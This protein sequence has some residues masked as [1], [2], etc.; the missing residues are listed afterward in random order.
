[1]LLVISGNFNTNTNSV[2]RHK[3]LRLHSPDGYEDNRFSKLTNLYRTDL[4]V[5]HHV[6]NALFGQA[7]FMPKSRPA[8]PFCVV[9]PTRN[10]K[11]RK[12]NENVYYNYNLPPPL[13][14]VA[15]GDYSNIGNCKTKYPAKYCWNFWRYFDFFYAKISGGI[16]FAEP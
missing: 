10:S 1:V 5:P 6:T 13:G 7:Q 4:K 11:H 9:R 14:F 12:K 2:A 8:E 3:Y 16:G 15:H